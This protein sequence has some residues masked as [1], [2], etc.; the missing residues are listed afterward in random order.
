MKSLTRTLAATACGVALAV[1]AAVPALAYTGPGRL[2]SDGGIGNCLAYFGQGGQG[3]LMVTAACVA[4]AASQDINFYSQGTV[5]ANGPFTVARFNT[6]Y[7]GD[8]VVQERIDGLCV[9]AAFD[10]ADGVALQPCGGEQSR[11]WVQ[12]G[13]SQEVVSVLQT[14]LQGGAETL[15]DFGRGT[16]VGLT[17]GW[18][19]CGSFGGKW[20][21]LS[22]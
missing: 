5:T 9:T 4:H 20:S 16:E 7:Y 3:D 12:N 8:R 1:A 11:L 19:V 17:N 15:C 21:Y 13:Q 22:P 6:Q 10:P 2:A 18:A 14:D